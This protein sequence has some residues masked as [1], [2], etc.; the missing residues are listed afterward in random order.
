MR[1]FAECLADRRDM[2]V[3]IGLFHE[4]IRPELLHESALLE[5]L[6]VVP[7]EQ[8]QHV[9]RLWRQRHRASRAQE[10][11]LRRQEAV[12]VERKHHLIR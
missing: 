5:D 4:R 11:P 7:H 9:E 12:L 10:L 2:H 6:A 3:Q 8:Q 1:A